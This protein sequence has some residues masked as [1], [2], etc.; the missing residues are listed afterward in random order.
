MDGRAGT[1][2]CVGMCGSGHTGSPTGSCRVGSRD[3]IVGE[4]PPASGKPLAQKIYQN[5]AKWAPHP[6][7]ILMSFKKR[8][9]PACLSWLHR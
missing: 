7:V 4:L 2:G 9:L 3:E 1:G 8:D 5:T 6:I